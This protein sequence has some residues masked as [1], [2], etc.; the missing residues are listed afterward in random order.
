MVGKGGPPP[1]NIVSK[2]V[3]PTF[4]HNF[5]ALPVTSS[6][7]IPALETLFTRC[8]RGTKKRFVVS[9]P[10]YFLLLRARFNLPLTPLIWCKKRVKSTEITVLDQPQYRFHFFCRSIVQRCQRKIL[11]SIIRFGSH[12]WS[13]LEFLTGVCQ[14]KSVILP[15]EYYWKT[16]NETKDNQ[17]N[18]HSE[19]HDAFH[20]EP[21]LTKLSTLFLLCLRRLVLVFPWKSD[22]VSWLYKQKS[23]G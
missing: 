22:H 12:R 6:S 14:V 7:T 2:L 11:V 20:R 4:L 1:V 19:N 18:E 21:I 17:L 3:L 16:E 8:S 9:L 23:D 15:V 5:F 10:S 13:G